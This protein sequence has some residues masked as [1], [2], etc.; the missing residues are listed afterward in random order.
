[1]KDKISLK[2]LDKAAVLSALYNASHDQGLGFLEYDPAPMTAEEAQRLLDE[3]T[4]FD[5][6][7]GRVMK[8][9][10]G[11]N[12]LDPYFYDRDNGDGA[13]AKIID[14]L[15]LRRKHGKSKKQ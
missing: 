15:R 7:K 3:D 2:G 5:Y 1:M 4:D 6:L 11:G 14:A 10:L 8:V 9:N 13:A 12:E